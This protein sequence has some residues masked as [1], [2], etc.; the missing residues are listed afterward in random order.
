VTDVVNIAVQPASADVPRTELPAAV[1]NGNLRRVIVVSSLVVPPLIQF[2][3]SQFIFRSFGLASVGAAATVAVIAAIFAMVADINVTPRLLRAIVQ[4]P[5]ESDAWHGGAL[6][7]WIV[8]TISS[9]A[10]ALL[11]KVSGALDGLD[12]GTGSWLMAGSLGCFN[13]LTQMSSQRAAVSGRWVLPAV[14][15]IGSAGA[16]GLAIVVY[17]PQTVQ[18]FAA[19]SLPVA[20]VVGLLSVRLTMR[21]IGGWRRSPRR[22]ELVKEL[23]STGM[24]VTPAAIFNAG[25]LMLHLLIVRALVGE[26]DLGLVRIGSLLSTAFVTLCTTIVIRFIAPR[27]VSVWL[28]PDH[29]FVRPATRQLLMM[30]ALAG[31]L[32]VCGGPLATGLLFGLG[33]DSL[34]LAAA[35]SFGDLLRVQTVLLSSLL[36]AKGEN[37]RVLGVEALFACVLLGSV[38]PGV[39]WLGPIGATLSYS[40]AFGVSLVGYVWIMMAR[41]HVLQFV[42]AVLCGGVVLVAAAVAVI[43]VTVST[44]FGLAIGFPV[45]VVLVFLGRRLRQTL[46]HLESNRR[47]TLKAVLLE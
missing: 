37:K 42:D 34:R 32:A 10:L 18:D 29:A 30:V 22:R 5:H 24:V 19:T 16:T 36:L 45:S 40:A 17:R 15:S 2:G 47:K 21:S 6:A 1:R 8:G 12:I 13:M 14:I 39:K 26:S 31:V 43:I 33:E 35:S 11:M 23:V 28:Q 46:E 44:W 41:L 25:A 7:L 3:V 4:F 38:I 9:L 20:V 27:A